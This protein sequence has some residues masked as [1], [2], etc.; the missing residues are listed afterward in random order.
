MRSVIGGAR[1][2]A[3]S[4][5]GAA[6]EQRYDGAQCD[7]RKAEQHRSADSAGRARDA[8]LLMTCSPV[9]R[10]YRLSIA[11]CVGTKSVND[12]NGLHFRQKR[13]SHLD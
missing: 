2:A 8:R 13:I 12:M 3:W 7:L 11:R 5:W 9:R 6:P 1:G 4:H 10:F